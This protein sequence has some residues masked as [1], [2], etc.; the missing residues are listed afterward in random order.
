MNDISNLRDTIIPKSDQLN[1]EMLLAGPMTITV[2]GVLRGPEEQPLAIQYQNDAG[3]AFKPCKSMRKVL[4]FAWGEDGREWVGR[5]MTLYNNPD[6]KFGRDRVGG[7]RISHLSHIERDISLSLTITKGKKE[8]FIIKR[9][10]V[11]EIPQ[12]PDVFGLENAA[13][14][15]MAS[16][17]KAWRDAVPALRQAIGKDGLERLKKTAQEADER[18]TASE[19]APVAAHDV[20]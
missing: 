11:S 7:V 3:R 4:L 13:F 9:M 6:V 12:S 2:T 16:L 1:A 5:S 19:P 15:G 10:L 8:E 20:F 17:E 14:L 18:A